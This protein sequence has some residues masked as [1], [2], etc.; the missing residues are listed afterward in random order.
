MVKTIIPLIL[1]AL[2]GCFADVPDGFSHDGK[3]FYSEVFYELKDTVHYYTQVGLG[4]DSF[5]QNWTIST[6]EESVGYVTSICS[7]TTQHRCY[8]PDKF[9]WGIDQ[10]NPSDACIKDL[11]QNMISENARLNDGDDGSFVDPIPNYVLQGYSATN[12]IEFYN[13][14]FGRKK[15]LE[16][17]SFAIM[18]SNNFDFK[19]PYYSGYLGL[20]PY[21]SDT[22]IRGENIIYH[23]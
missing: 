11:S 6:Q 8:V 4:C 12:R 3:F 16:M 18:Q 22:N 15:Q 13:R 2:T 5:K 9:P 17:K 23:L 10:S 1:A 7:D 19:S 20:G 21:S 14:D